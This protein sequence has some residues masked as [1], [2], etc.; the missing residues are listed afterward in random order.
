[1]QACQDQCS[2]THNLRCIHLCHSFRFLLN[3]MARVLYIHQVLSHDQMNQQR[4]L[5]VCQL[6]HSQ[7]TQQRCLHRSIYQLA[8]QLDTNLLVLMNLLVNQHE[9]IVPIEKEHLG[10]KLLNALMNLLVNQHET[11]VPIEREQLNKRSQI[12]LCALDL[13]DSLD[14]QPNSSRRLADGYELNSLL[15]ELVEDVEL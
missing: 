2:P 10:V 8:S 7:L 3:Q 4:I 6:V 13:R 14:L 9:T 15:V 12:L 1:M 5:M 11:N